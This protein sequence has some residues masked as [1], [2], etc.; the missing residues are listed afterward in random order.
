MTASTVTHPVE[1]AAC[2]AAPRGTV[3]RPSNVP[4]ARVDASSDRRVANA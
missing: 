3:P 4:A 2:A 1:I